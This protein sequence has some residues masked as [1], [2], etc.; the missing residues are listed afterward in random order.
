M[1]IRR[2]DRDSKGFSIPRI[3][4]YSTIVYERWNCHI[5]TN[6]TLTI[7][8]LYFCLEFDK[9]WE[10]LGLNILGLI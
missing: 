1:S 2:S 9:R 8:K 7:S 6:G 5:D 4:I 10:Y 3:I